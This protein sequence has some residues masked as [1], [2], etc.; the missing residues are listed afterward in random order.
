MPLSASSSTSTMGLVMTCFVRG[1]PSSYLPRRR[2]SYIAA[3]ASAPCVSWSLPSVVITASREK[4][5]D[6]LVVAGVDELGVAVEQVGDRDGIRYPT[7]GCSLPSSSTSVNS[8]P[9][10]PS[11]HSATSA[12]STCIDRAVAAQ[13]LHAADDPLE[14][15]HGGAAVA[16]RHRATVGRDRVD[17]RR[18]RWCRPS[19]SRRPR[20]RRRSR[21]PRTGG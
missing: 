2:S 1:V 8:A 3:T 7:H 20:L 17:A 11:L 13:L 4:G 5:A 6:S 9:A 10:P 12:P 21:T 18:A 16:E 14:H 15:L 19:R